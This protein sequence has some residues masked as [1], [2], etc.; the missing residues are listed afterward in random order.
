MVISGSGTT[1]RLTFEGT[2]DAAAVTEH[3]ADVERVAAMPPPRTL[4]VEL[5]RLT[6]LDPSG[7]AL[8]VVL[9][10][11]AS[12]QGVR[13]RLENLRGQ[14]AQVFGVLGLPLAA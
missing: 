10:R 4:V 6:R 7:V 14:P 8:L 9:L 1:I 11:R 3:R 2:L 5:G 13:V 12:A